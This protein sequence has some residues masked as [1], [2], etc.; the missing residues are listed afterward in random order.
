MFLTLT[1]VSISFR[2]IEQQKIWC[3]FLSSEVFRPLFWES[4]FG[5]Y[6]GMTYEQLPCG[7]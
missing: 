6:F 5:G 7:L 4:F 3:V 2:L 1:A